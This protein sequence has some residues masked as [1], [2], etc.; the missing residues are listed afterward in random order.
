MAPTT[1]RRAAAAQ[2]LMVFEG[3]RDAAGEVPERR[4]EEELILNALSYRHHNLATFLANAVGHNCQT[5]QPLEHWVLY[6]FARYLPQWLVRTWCEDPSA[7]RLREIDQL[8]WARNARGRFRVDGLLKVYGQFEQFQ[9]A[10]AEL[11]SELQRLGLSVDSLDYRTVR[12][13]F[14]LTWLA[15]QP[16]ASARRTAGT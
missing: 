16:N 2:G 1:S 6:A 3:G 8:T 11:G 12:H 15:T 10:F 13:L 9:E 4:A 5:E 14:A 7:D